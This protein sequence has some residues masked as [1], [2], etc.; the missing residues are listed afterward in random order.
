[1]NT[2]FV[3]TGSK[4]NNWRNSQSVGPQSYFFKAA[5]YDENYHIKPLMFSIQYAKG[6]RKLGL[7]FL[8]F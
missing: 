2:H 1:M 7:I 5:E 3:L 4:N 8:N 6:V